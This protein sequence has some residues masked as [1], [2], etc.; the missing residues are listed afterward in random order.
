M[1]DLNRP[2]PTTD[3]Y[4]QRT[5][6]PVERS[7]GFS[8]MYL[9]LGALVVAVAVLAFA[10]SGPDTAEE[11]RA[12]TDA[13]AVT[14]PAPSTAPSTAPSAAPTAPTEPSSPPAGGAP[15]PAPAQ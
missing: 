10:F 13:P 3:P 5:T 14:E 1:D 6:P 7:S 8:S 15:A 9:I 12:G 4:N 2:G 11:G